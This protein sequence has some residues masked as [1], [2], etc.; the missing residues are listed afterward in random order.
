MSC[1]HSV[2][3]TRGADPAGEPLI[4]C[5][6]AACAPW[7]NVAQAIPELILDI[8]YAGHRNFMGRPAQGYAQALCLLSQ[9][10]AHHLRRAVQAAGALGLALKVFDA[11][12][13][14][15]A[16]DDFVRWSRD[17]NDQLMKSQYYPRVDKRD[18]LASG[19]IA[20]RSS[21]SRGSAVDVTLVVRNPGSGDLHPADAL[22]AQSLELDM[23]S[24][25]DLFDPLSHIA[26]PHLPVCCRFNRQLLQQLMNDAGFVGIA[27]EWWHFSLRDEPYASTYFDFPL[28]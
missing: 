9:P 13:P 17:E 19:Y 1:R 22:M 3:E 25:F 15:R 21:H 28:R 4:A 27:E 6:T 20:A 5:D 18:L 2:H 10:A 11:Y 26:C 14:Q 23:G 16:V 7:V 12:R 8:R 24:P